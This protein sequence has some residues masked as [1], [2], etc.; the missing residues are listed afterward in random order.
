MEKSK[1]YGRLNTRKLVLT[2]L[3]IA[4]VVVLQLV[5]SSIPLGP[6]SLSFVLVPIVIGAA[7]LGWEVGAWLGLVFS[8]VVLIKPDGFTVLMLG[9]NA[10]MTWVV[11][12]L[13]GTAAGAVA[14]LL[15]KMLSKKNETLAIIVSAV[16]C[17]IVNTGIFL[18][19]LRLFFWPIATMIGDSY[20]YISTW[21]FV[22][23][24]ILVFC[25]LPELVIN[26]VLS[27]VIYRIIQVGKKL[28]KKS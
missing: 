7:M 11:A 10:P 26:L 1:S 28:W 5:A 20:N 6:L 12:L 16:S 18:I 4:I 15:Y 25:F 21:A 23:I 19:G 17:P 14:G 3:L 2:A 24:G 9:H 22:G 27:P 8:V 13:K